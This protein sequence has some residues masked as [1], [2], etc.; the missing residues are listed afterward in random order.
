MDKALGNS[1]NTSKELISFVK[2]RPGH[3]K[4]YA[5]DASKIHTELGWSPSVKFEE[6]LEKTIS[7]Y[8]DILGCAI[9]R[10][11]KRWVDFDFFGHQ[12]SAHLSLEA[13]KSMARNKVDSKNIPVRHF[14]IIL[15]KKEWEFLA[16]KLIDINIE[17]IVAADNPPID[18]IISEQSITG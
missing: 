13:K 6:G 1:P 9:G 16:Q 12:I 4:R 3:D 17:F 5:I 18:Q 15:D 8:T 7:W 2:D 14:G 10:Q 11:H